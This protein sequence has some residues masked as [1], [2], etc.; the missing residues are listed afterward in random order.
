[1]LNLFLKLVVAMIVVA[2]AVVMIVVV[3]CLFVFISG[4]E[5]TMRFSDTAWGHPRHS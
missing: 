2:V 4:T 5:R 1:V 3:V